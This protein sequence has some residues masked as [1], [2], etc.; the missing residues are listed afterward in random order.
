MDPL[1]YGGRPIS[2]HFDL[3]FKFFDLKEIFQ[4]FGFEYNQKLFFLALYILVLLSKNIYYT[5][6]TESYLLY[7]TKHQQLLISPPQKLLQNN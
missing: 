7:L 2:R 4:S 1:S 3:F 5:D 6:Y